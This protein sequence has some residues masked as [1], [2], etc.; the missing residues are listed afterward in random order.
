MVDMVYSLLLLLLL[1]LLLV[2]L[3]LYYIISSALPVLVQY[4]LV[5]LTL[6]RKGSPLAF[7]L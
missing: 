5:T 3:L 7:L 1:L 2:S 4:A 6:F